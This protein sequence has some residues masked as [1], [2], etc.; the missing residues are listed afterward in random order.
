M[1]VGAT[2]AMRRASSSPARVS[3]ELAIA[4][5]AETVKGSR[6]SSRAMS[7][8]RVV[9]ASSVSPGPSPGATAIERRKLTAARWEIWTP[10]GRPVE[11][12]VKIM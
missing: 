6:S 8:D 12:E 5:R 1:A 3:A 9:T 11:P 10:F 2:S 7:N 4:T